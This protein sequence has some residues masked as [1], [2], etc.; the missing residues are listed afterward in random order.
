MKTKHYRQ[1]KYYY[2]RD[3]QNRP[4]V[5]VCLICND[6]GIWSRGIAI[7][8]KSDNPCKKVGRKLA[9]QRAMKANGTRNSSLY[10]KDGHNALDSLVIG[11]NYKSRYNLMEV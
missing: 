6:G 9:Y 8:S 2:L 1:T 3:K 4:I 5:T 11:K 7:C 10:I